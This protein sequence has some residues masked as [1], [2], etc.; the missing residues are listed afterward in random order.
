MQKNEDRLFE[1]FSELNNDR[2]RGH[3]VIDKSGVKMVETLCPIMKLDPR[4]KVLD[5]GARKTPEKY[6][7]AEIEWYD[8]Q[9]LSVEEIGKKAKIWRDVADKN[10]MINSNYGW[11]IYSEENGSQYK[12]CLEELKLNK[13][14]RRAV[15]IYQRPSMWEDYNRDG[16]S[17]FMCTDG[18]QIFIRMD[19]LIYV[20]KQ[21]SSDAIYGFFNDFYW[22][23]VV[24]ERLFDDLKKIYPELKDGAIYFHPF[25]FHVYER[26]FDML[27]NMVRSYD[28]KDVKDE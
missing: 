16:M 24:Y 3:F 13:F 11:C 15:M 14:S 7:K 19:M 1:F 20:V 22:H 6:A 26:H 28:L 17:D 2:I 21:R 23:C 9:S 25:S 27:E 5:F 8:S 10:G 18:V 4:Q 12:N